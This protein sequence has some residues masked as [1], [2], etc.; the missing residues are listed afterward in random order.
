MTIGTRSVFSLKGPVR[1]ATIACDS[2]ML[3]ITQAGDVRDYVI[4]AGKDFTVP[5]EGSVAIQLLN[6]AGVTVRLPDRYPDRLRRLFRRC[7]LVRAAD[8]LRR[9]PRS[10]PAPG[11]SGCCAPAGSNRLEGGGG[12]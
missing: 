3:W 1:G 7:R 9:R 5:G 4:R 2:G 12:R 11:S 8:S 10:V 6:D